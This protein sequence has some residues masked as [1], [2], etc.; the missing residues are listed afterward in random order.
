MVESKVD[1]F[2]IGLFDQRQQ[3][4]H[5]LLHL[6]HLVQP[7]VTHPRAPHEMNTARWDSGNPVHVK[8]LGECSVPC[9]RACNLEHPIVLSVTGRQRAAQGVIEFSWVVTANKGAD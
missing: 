9:H 4:L 3:R 1:N 5:E 6:L 2:D 8:I 7:D